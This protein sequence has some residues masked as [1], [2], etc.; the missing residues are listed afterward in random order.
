MLFTACDGT[1]GN[2]LITRK[3]A[4][5]YVGEDYK[6]IIHLAQGR[7]LDGE[8][9]ATKFLINANAR[10]EHSVG[11]MLQKNDHALRQSLYADR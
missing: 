4:L 5:V 9:V 8:G 1:L 11:Q 3:D 2:T 10:L 6:S 7:A